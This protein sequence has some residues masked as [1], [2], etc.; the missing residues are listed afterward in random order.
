M[1]TPQEIERERQ[2]DLLFEEM[3]EGAGALSEALLQEETAECFK[4]FVEQ[5]KRFV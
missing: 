1:P 5:R 2:L 4:Y 3:L